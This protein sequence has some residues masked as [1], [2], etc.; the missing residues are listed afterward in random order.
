MLEESLELHGSL[1]SGFIEERQQEGFEDEDIFEGNL[2]EEV[3]EFISQGDF[4]EGR[5]FFINKDFH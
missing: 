3:E 5:D 4:M 1:A 2:N